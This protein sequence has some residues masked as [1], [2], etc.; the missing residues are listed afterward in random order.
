MYEGNSKSSHTH[1]HTQI[2][3]IPTAEEPNLS[4]YLYKH[5]RIELKDEG[6][7]RTDILSLL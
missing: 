6:Y 3:I 1:T 5:T 7:S 4:N 2:I